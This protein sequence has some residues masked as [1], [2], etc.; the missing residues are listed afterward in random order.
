M[1]IIDDDI[2]FSSLDKSVDIGAEPDDEAPTI[3]EFVDERP[4]HIR[5][6]EEYR[7]TGRWKTL[8][9]DEQMQGKNMQA[10]IYTYLLMHIYLY[11][12]RLF[13]FNDMTAKSR[14]RRELIFC[15][16]LVLTDDDSKNA[17]EV[18]FFRTG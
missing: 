13:N 12:L 15:E 6:L 14:S 16:I 11:I 2:D 7:N 18:F 9:K 1:K 10:S 17:G 5:Q 8:G 3:A 4:E